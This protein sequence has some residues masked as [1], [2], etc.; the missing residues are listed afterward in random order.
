MDW[1]CIHVEKQYSQSDFMLQNKHRLD[2]PFCL[3]AQFILA[4]I[5]PTTYLHHG[6]GS[7]QRIELRN[8]KF[9]IKSLKLHSHSLFL[10]FA[11]YVFMLVLVVQ[12][13]R[14]TDGFHIDL[15]DFLTGLLLLANEMVSLI[16]FSKLYLTGVGHFIFQRILKSQGLF[17]D[18]S[19]AGKVSAFEY[20]S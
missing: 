19:L 5:L 16:S 12:V 20:T 15:D 18:K 13:D 4:A 17:F 3:S 11:N 14:T 6:N 2:E 1:H 10:I 8:S 7:I 9:Q